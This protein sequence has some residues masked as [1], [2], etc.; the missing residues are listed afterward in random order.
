MESLPRI[1]TS[2][3]V[4]PL[5]PSTLRRKGVSGFWNFIEEIFTP[6][7]LLLKTMSLAVGVVRSV[8]TVPKLTV[9]RE[10]ERV[11]SGESVK[12]SL[13]HDEI[14]RPKIMQIINNIRVKTFI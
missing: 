8:N 4:E 14:Q 1:S 5:T 10:K 3:N 6:F 13:M 2:E 9:S 7:L 11:A 12:S